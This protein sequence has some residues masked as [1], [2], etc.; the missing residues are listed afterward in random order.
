MSMNSFYSL[1]YNPFSKEN[2]SVK[3]SFESYDQKEMMHRLNYLK[4]VRGIGVFTAAPGMG[5]SFTL[6]RFEASL[7]PNLFSVKYICLSTVTVSEFYKQLCSRL[8]IST[9]GGKTEMFKSL[10]TY[11]YHLYRDKKQTLILII[12]EAQY[13]KTSVLMNLKMLMN[14]VYD[15]LNC[16][17]LILS[18]E[19]HLNNTLEL[20]V[21]EA[22]RQR[23]VTHYD[24]RGLNPT[25]VT[26]YVYHKL[27]LAGGSESIINDEALL[28]LAGY[29]RGN[30]RIIDNVMSTALKYGSDLEYRTIN[31]ELMQMAI[32]EQ[33]LSK[34]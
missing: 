28:A 21:H 26:S 32:S 29:C 34:R 22:L 8:A 15:S 9:R 5:K 33:S 11:I 19:S 1:S 27:H 12:D 3:D 14:F 20:T 13:L 4:D 16:F 17:T 6:H 25:E 30:P 23:I 7:N 18:G 2:Q 10:Q 24:F 31:A